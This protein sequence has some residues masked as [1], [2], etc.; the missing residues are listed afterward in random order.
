[1]STKIADGLKRG[2][3]VRVAAEQDTDVVRALAGKAHEIHGECDVDTFFLRGL[4]RPCLRVAE[5]P[6]DNDHPRI[7]GPAVGLPVTGPRGL[8]L[9]IGA[10]TA[11]V[12]TDCRELTA[13]RSTIDDPPRHAHGINMTMLAR[14]AGG[15]EP[16]AAATTRGHP[17]RLDE[18]T[19]ARPGR[20]RS[21]RSETRRRNG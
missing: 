16:A 5:L 21:G 2:H 17:P 8:R 4:G 12:D 15:Q 13:E 14:C 9:V 11:A 10:G 1:M 6:A 19:P 20:V 7:T 3:E 18:P